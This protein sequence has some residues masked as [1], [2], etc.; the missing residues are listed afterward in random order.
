M[1]LFSVSSWQR[2]SQ[3]WFLLS[4][5]LSSL[6]ALFYIFISVQFALLWPIQSSYLLSCFLLGAQRL[7]RSGRVNKKKTMCKFLGRF[8]FNWL[9]YKNFW[10]NSMK[11]VNVSWIF[12]LSRRNCLKKR[13]NNFSIPFFIT[14]FL[15]MD[16]SKFDWFLPIWLF[17]QKQNQNVS[18]KIKPVKMKC[19]SEV[20]RY[21]KVFQHMKITKNFR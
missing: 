11:I 5:N 9:I 18:S 2:D 4:S 15:F 13:P 1:Y 17:K 6:S 10:P 14:I 16:W 21:I 7:G 19:F 20:S 12:I 8:W 3:I